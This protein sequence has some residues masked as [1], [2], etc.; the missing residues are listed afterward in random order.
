LKFDGTN[1][2]VD[3]DGDPASLRN[4]PSGAFSACAW[5]YLSRS[6][7]ADDTVGILGKGIWW[8][9]YI[10]FGIRN[11]DGGNPNKLFA[12]ISN[13]AYS[14]TNS[15]TSLNTWHYLC[16]T[17]DDAGDRKINLY[18]DG[19]EVV[20]N[21]ETAM[22]GSYGDDTGQ[23]MSIGMHDGG[24]FWPGAIDDF[25]VYDYVRTPA[26]IAWDYNRGAPVAWYKFDEC[27]GAIAYNSV[28][29]AKGEAAGMNGTITIGAQSD[30]DATGTCTSG[31]SGDAW[32]N[33]ASGKFNASLAFDGSDDKVVV[34]QDERINLIAN[35]P[36]SISYWVNLDRVDGTYQA[37]IMKGTFSSSFGH[38]IGTSSKYL[39]IYT[40]DDVGSEMTNTNFFVDA[41][42]GNWV[43]VTQTYDG[44]KIYVYKNGKYVNASASGI[45]LT[46]NT[47][48]LYMGI[49]NNANYLMDGKLDDV[50][51]Y[52]YA[53]TAVQ[54]KQ[55]HNEGSSVRF[56]E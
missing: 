43:M 31:D 2:Y 44:D 5:A 27:T 49:N 54:V 39:L 1:D 52:N 41:D 55:V 17:Y 6:P 51:I 22:S 25:K 15:Q 40:D 35:L 37:P 45:T 42:V 13:V 30:Q 50:R 4:L 3:I 19:V 11:N 10:S 7:V 28:L 16:M 12:T 48:S 24:S 18:Q 21:T 46:T 56:V 29:N 9:D 23:D 26:Q 47:S 8:S 20:Y 32:Y 53:L 36:F 14:M 33:G 38:L 34:T